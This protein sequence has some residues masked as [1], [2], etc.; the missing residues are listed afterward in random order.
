MPSI[1]RF[2]PRNPNSSLPVTCFGLRVPG[3]RENH[4]LGVGDFLVLRC[5]CQAEVEVCVYQLLVQAF[6][7][8][9]GFGL[10]P[11][12]SLLPSH[13]WGTWESC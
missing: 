10:Q 12:S 8:L 7:V 3:G 4:F 11:A 5:L 13:Q 1:I 6:W 9:E 2:F